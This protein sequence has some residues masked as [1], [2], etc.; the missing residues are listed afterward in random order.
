MRKTAWIA[1]WGTT[2][3]AGFAAGIAIGKARLPEVQRH[4]PV[5]RTIPDRKDREEARLLASLDEFRNALTEKE[6][7]AAGLRAEIE[8]VRGKMLPPLSPEDEKWLNE[9]QE[10]DKHRQ[11]FKACW[12]RS[13]ELA[14]RILQRRD[15]VL[16]EEGLGELESLL[17]ANSAENKLVG[18][19]SLSRIAFEGSQFDADR[20]KPLA[21]AALTHDD[22]QVRETAL[23]YLGDQGWHGDRQGAAET[24]LTMVTDTD[25]K[26][27]KTALRILVQF[28]GRERNED[29][30]TA[31]K[32]LLQEGDRENTS[33]ALQTMRDLARESRYA[34]VGEGGLQARAPDKAYDCY[35]E[36][37]QD[38]I[39]AS[40]SPELQEEVLEFW[41]GRETLGKEELE[42]GSEILNRVDPEDKLTVGYGIS[43]DM[44]SRV[45]YES[46][47]ASPELR[48]QAN[49]YY[50]RVI[51]ESL[52]SQR[53]WLAIIRLTDSKDKSLIPELKAIGASE[54][55]EGIERG[56]E[57]AIKHLEQDGK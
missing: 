17:K 22:P 49:R 3:V 18:L 50:L 44:Y 43:P 38:V 14:K 30:V 24:A 7:I 48:Q 29:V 16:R 52:D 42:L 11:R 28:G 19:L 12:K 46:N 5:T 6:Q 56:I 1:L 21:Q 40:R 25:P 23:Q 47:P 9:R 20:F 57:N 54:D 13:E 45:P 37:R 53:R 55:A 41:W 10:E 39:A 27:K 31:L 32:S 15:K 2:L 34:S 26:V 36:M 4:Q 51:R 35:E 8:E 33:V